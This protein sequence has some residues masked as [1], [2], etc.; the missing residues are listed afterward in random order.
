[1]SAEQPHASPV[2]LPQQSG[3]WATVLIVSIGLMAL[4][5]FSFLKFS[6]GPSLRLGTCFQDVGDLRRGARVRLAGVDV[7]TVRDVRAQPSNKAC[8][9]AV[10]ME[11]RTPYELK[12]PKD[13]VAATATAG[14]LGETYLEIDVSGTSAPP[15]QSG[16]Q[17]PSKESARFTAATVDRALKAVELLKQLSDEERNNGAQP[18]SKCRPDAAPSS[19]H[20]VS[21]VPK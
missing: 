16:G 2:G 6:I 17:L 18:S 15:I 12:I 1:M 21:A 8:P 4:A 11:L 19:A 9:G 20:S 7:G 13:S 14:I 10:E 3:R 5:G